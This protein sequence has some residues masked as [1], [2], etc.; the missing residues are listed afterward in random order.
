ML[1]RLSISN[2]VLIN[3]LDIVFPD[4]LI[5]ISGET[6]SGKS[7]LL[8]AISLL[9]G[10]K[11]DLSVLHD[12]GRNCVVEAEFSDRKGN[13]YI[14]RRVITP[15]GRSRSFLNDEPV[16]LSVL[17]SISGS[18]IDIHA[19][20]QHL[21]LAD[22]DFR[23]SALDNFA[24][25]SAEL[26]EYRKAFAELERISSE[27]KLLENE[28][29]K[30]LSEAEYNEFRLARLNE[31][32]LVP[33]EQEELEDEQRLL[34]NAE[35]IRGGLEYALSLLSPEE[36]PVTARLK[37]AIARISKY[38]AFDSRLETLA[39]R[40]ESCRVEIDDIVSDLDRI[41]D[42]VTVSP[43]RLEEVE[44]RLS[45]LYSLMRKHNCTT[46]DE[47][48]ALRDSLATTIAD[49]AEMEHK[50][51]DMRSLQQ[52]AESRVQKLSGFLTEKRRASL[53][54][55]NSFMTDSIRN[56]E[57]PSAIFEATLVRK[58]EFTADGCDSVDFLFSA[59]GDR[60]QDIS[61]VASGGELSRVML[62][63]K[64]MLAKYTDL[65]TMI[66]D[67]IDTGVS[68][69]IAD[70]MGQMIG[71]M[72]RSMQIFAITHLPQIASKPGTH[73]LVYKES[74]ENGDTES[75]IRQIEG[76]DR[77]MEVARMLSGSRLTPAAIENAKALLSENALF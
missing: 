52:E 48:M 71:E 24:G 17:T 66:F 47:L 65:P 40:L 64:G 5:I 46:L 3:S 57:M 26:A 63:L 35:E 38:S 16:S 11:A 23:L 42:S 55:L 72:G 20:H 6:G 43:K 60:P 76:E 10:K 32:S 30:A 67:E 70:R 56:L 15:A 69:K 36:M 39:D 2:Y 51:Q 33:G 62:A 31:A 37:D 22:P 21:Q 59:N 28:L 34:S 58:P 29:A 7:I 44:D 74:A 73:F 68:G 54:A 1:T 25:T 50:L 75:R 53:E 49:N 18:I 61:K 27:V 14:L 8:G 19:Q 77:V 41:C 45:L 4:G 12:K 13:E 9:L